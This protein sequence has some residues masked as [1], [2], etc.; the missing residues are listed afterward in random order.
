MRA[1]KVQKGAQ[2]FGRVFGAAGVVGADQN[3][4]AGALGNEYSYRDAL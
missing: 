4:G 1:G 3:D 2:G